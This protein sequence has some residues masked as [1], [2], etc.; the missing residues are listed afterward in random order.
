VVPLSTLIVP[1]PVLKVIPLFVPK[2]KLAEV[3]KVPPANIILSASA[4]S[5]VAPNP[6]AALIEIVPSSIVVIPV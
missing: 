4:E 6:V 2:V 3:F 5:G 1:P